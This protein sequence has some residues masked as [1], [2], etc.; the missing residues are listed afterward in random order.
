MKWLPQASPR[1]Y[2]PRK[3]GTAVELLKYNSSWGNEY[4]TH[5]TMVLDRWAASLGSVFH[6]ELL[7]GELSLPRMAISPGDGIISLST[8]AHTFTMCHI[9]LCNLCRNDL[10]EAKPVESR[11]AGVQCSVVQIMCVYVGGTIKQ[12]FQEPWTASLLQASC[13]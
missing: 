4:P 13:L 7:Y 5:V 9:W 11:V 12:C 3:I 6:D 1:K 8:R 2:P 10:L